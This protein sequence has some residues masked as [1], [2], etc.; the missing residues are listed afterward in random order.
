MVLGRLPFWNYLEEGD[1]KQNDF[2]WS[3]NP[4]I[5]YS[6]SMP[7]ASQLF[8]IQ[9]FSFTSLHTRGSPFSHALCIVLLL[10]FQA[11]DST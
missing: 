9:T 10:Q 2:R 8:H 4:S 7:V 6:E 3:L 1:W 5:C 11:R